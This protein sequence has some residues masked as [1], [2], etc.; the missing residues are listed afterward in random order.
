MMF[1]YT[2]TVFGPSLFG[3]LAS[4]FGFPKAYLVMGAAV[5]LGGI[6]GAFGRVGMDK[7]MNVEDSQY[8]P[9]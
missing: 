6:I 4:A 1:A 9:R 2:G 7:R 8:H 3:G 5:L